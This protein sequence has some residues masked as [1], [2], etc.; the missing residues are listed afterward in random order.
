[1]HHS[2]RK[3]I[4]C[5]I[6]GCDKKFKSNASINQHKKYFH[7]NIRPFE[8]PEK[9]CDKTFKTNGELIRHRITHSSDRPFNCDECVITARFKRLTNLNHN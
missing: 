4:S 3:S 9:D 6:K 2:D 7:C 5:D 8:C 1:M